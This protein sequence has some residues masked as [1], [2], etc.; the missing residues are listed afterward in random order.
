[1]AK[2]IFEHCFEQELDKQSGSYSCL[3]VVSYKN[4]I[5]VTGRGS[6]GPYNGY[7]PA[8]SST[9]LFNTSSFKQLIF[10]GSQQN[11]SFYNDSLDNDTLDDVL[12]EMFFI[13]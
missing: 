6:S 13:Q 12:Y 5:P 8:V 10:V 3:N 4:C 9:D 7:W 2:C 11:D 1:M